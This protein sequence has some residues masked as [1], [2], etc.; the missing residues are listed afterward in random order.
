[1]RATGILVAL[2][3][4][5]A[6]LQTAQAIRDA[7]IE[8]LAH[9]S[10]TLAPEFA[11]D[12]LLRLSASPRIR[13]AA[14]KRELIEEAWNRSYAAREL[15]RRA[16]PN[17]PA[18]SRAAAL[19]LAYDT[20]LDR[21]SLQA[22]AVLGMAGHSA[23]RA[24]EM[25]E[26][27][28]FELKAQPCEEPL[29]PVLDEYYSTLAALARGSFGKSIMERADA[30][31]FLELYMWKASRPTEMLSIARAVLD[32]RA[33]PG[34]AL[35]LESVLQWILE[36][37]VQEPRD[38]AT[39]GPD[40][41]TKIADVDRYDV[42]QSVLNGT[43]LRAFRRY[44]ARQLSGPR[45]ADS[46]AERPTL[47]A[48][49]RLVDRRAPSVPDLRPIAASENRPSRVAAVA[50][51]DRMW[52]TGESQRLRAEA[53]WLLGDRQRPR[54]AAFKN[55]REWQERAARFLQDLEIWNGA[56]EPVDADY[57]F[58]KSIL[59]TG[60]LEIAPQGAL[61][62]RALADTIA[63]LKRTA[64]REAPG[65]WYAHLSRLIDLARDRDRQP[66]LEALDASDHPALMT[67][68]RLERM[69]VED[70]RRPRS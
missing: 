68:G 12:T 13:D 20:K 32:Y 45:C 50:R 36:H 15:Y 8:E 10:A 39:A 9:R 24:R 61:K 3:L 43:L 56:R 59:L 60:F 52:Q 49:N 69:R 4:L 63:F 19:T 66:I 53:T 48:F 62:A 44:L 55:S 54:T 14:W 27:I 33:S 41:V 40:L 58:E 64:G 17:A 31:W 21:V 37:G 30:L 23:S 70:A 57:F 7:E 5:A 18:D 6:P 1:M 51:Y 38:F 11:A 42:S 2:I 47:D 26:W 16:A 35:Y 25:F 22:R 46:T 67:Y 28:D 34:D 65:A 29:V